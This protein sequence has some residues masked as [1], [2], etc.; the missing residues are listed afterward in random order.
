MTSSTDYS[1]TKTVKLLGQEVTLYRR[2]CY[3][4]EE[5]CWF[6]KDVFVCTDCSE[7]NITAPV[8]RASL[9]MSEMR[10]QGDSNSQR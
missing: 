6:Q 2:N 1:D 3:V 7:I 8:A 10:Y 5:P 9:V 4:C